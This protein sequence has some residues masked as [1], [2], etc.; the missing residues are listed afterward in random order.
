MGVDEEIVNHNTY[1]AHVA[2]DKWYQYWNIN[3]W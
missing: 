3:T 2:P 1:L